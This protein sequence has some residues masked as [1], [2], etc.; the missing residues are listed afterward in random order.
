MTLLSHPTPPHPPHPTPPPLP[1]PLVYDVVF[2]VMSKSNNS[3]GRL[4][5]PAPKTSALLQGMLHPLFEQS[6]F[7]LHTL[8][9]KCYTC[10]GAI[11]L[12]DIL[13]EP[14]TSLGDICC[15]NTGSLKGLCCLK[16]I[17]ITRLH[18]LDEALHH[19]ALGNNDIWNSKRTLHFF[20]GI[21]CKVWKNVGCEGHAA[22]LERVREPARIKGHI[23]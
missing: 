10:E 16:L 6:E 11:C 18:L 13:K 8:V 4:R 23:A 7:F 1:A 5:C 19:V 21:L 3:G 9:Q 12:K 2:S 20:K 22:S 14:C 15:R 17:Y